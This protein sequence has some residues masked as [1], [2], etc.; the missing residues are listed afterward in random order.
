MSIAMTLSTKAQD[1]TDA[2]R[3]STDELTGS[4]RVRAM[5]GAFGALGGDISAISINPAGSAIFTTSEAGATLGNFS[6]QNDNNFFN[7]LTT[8]NNNKF[9]LSQGGFVFVLNN[10]NDKANWK[11][12]SLGVNYDITNN[13]SNSN[14]IAGI[15]TNNSIDQ[16]FLAYAN[17]V[18]LGIMDAGSY[19]DLDNVSNS[20]YIID[21]IYQYLGQYDGFAQQQAF[22]AYQAYLIDPVSNDASNT[23]YVSNALYTN[24]VDQ[25]YSLETTGANR[26]FTFNFGAQYKDFLHLG[27]NLNSHVIDFKKRTYLSEIGFDAYS[28]TGD[29]STVQEIGFENY[30][31]VYGNGFSFQL[32]AIIKAGNNL[33]FGATYDSPTWY[34]IDEELSQGLFAVSVDDIGNEYDADQVYP[35]IT[36]VYETYKIKTS[37]KLSGSVAYV[38]GKKGLLSFDYSRKDYGS[39][40]FKPENNSYFRSQNQVINNSLTTANTYRLGG[41]Y[42]IDRFSLRGGYRFEESPYKNGVTVGDLTGYS[43]GVGYD[44]GATKLDISY[45]RAEQDS[46]YQLYSVGL[47][48]ASNITTIFQNIM[49]SLNFK[50]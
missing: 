10:T 7:T 15:N 42:R 49:I 30:L 28:S 29:Y 3:Y 40:K 8:E 33:R 46:M 36:N 5:S 6:T 2:L 1:I 47:T 50:L 48:D 19:P 17:G 43:L 21:Y 12:L 27:L 22:L 24:G 26:K 38:F 13:Y 9:D 34:S 31:E 25:Q 16:Y 18:E 45:D 23:G 35:N 41:E 11:K 20:Q 14:F 37:G 32:G 39:I 44:F 4:A